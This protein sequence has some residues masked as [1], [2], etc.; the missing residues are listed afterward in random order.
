MRAAGRS[1]TFACVALD[2]LPARNPANAFLRAV[3]VEPDERADEHAEPAGLRRGPLLVFGG[4]GGGFVDD[5]TEVVDVG[6]PRESVIGRQPSVTLS[7]GVE[8]WARPDRRVRLCSGEVSS[9]AVL[10]TGRGEVIAWR[11][12]NSMRWL[13]C[14]ALGRPRWSTTRHRRGRRRWREPP[15]GLR[16]EVRASHR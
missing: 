11:L 12:G 6:L 16:S 4:T 13:L 15:A 10:P 3:A 7:G 2:C 1:T 9:V 8:P 14:V 5:A